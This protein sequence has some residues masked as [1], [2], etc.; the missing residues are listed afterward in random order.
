MEIKTISYVGYK[1]TA[2]EVGVIDNLYQGWTMKTIEDELVS[3][4]DIRENLEW[5]IKDTKEDMVNTSSDLPWS[6]EDD[7]WLASL[8]V[9]ERQLTEVEGVGASHIQF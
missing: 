5:I 2:I 8:I 6:K 4:K 1:E 9:L 3:I 7:E